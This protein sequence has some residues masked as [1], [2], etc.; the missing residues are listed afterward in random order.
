M[1]FFLSDHIYVL[2]LNN[3][4][5]YPSGRNCN[6]VVLARCSR[7]SMITRVVWLLI[8]FDYLLLGIHL[9]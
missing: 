3:K 6:V 4:I 7:D 9:V 1:S 5:V 8:F 2:F